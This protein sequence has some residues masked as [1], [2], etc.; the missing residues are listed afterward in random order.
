MPTNN[1]QNQNQGRQMDTL[2][3]PQGPHGGGSSFLRLPDPNAMQGHDQGTPYNKQQVGH[4]IQSST[5]VRMDKEFP[6]GLDAEARKRRKDIFD[7]F[8]V[9]SNNLLS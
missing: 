7:R 1:N 4:M 3:F 8:D 6:T 2:G 5:I 9:N